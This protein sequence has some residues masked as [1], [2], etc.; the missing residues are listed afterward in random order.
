[1]KGLAAR[2]YQELAETSIGVPNISEE[3]NETIIDSIGTKEIK[4]VEGISKQMEWDVMGPEKEVRGY[5]K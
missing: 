1:M 3:I 4:L 5:I 2:E